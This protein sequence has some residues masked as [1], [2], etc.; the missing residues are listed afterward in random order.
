MSSLERIRPTYTT[1]PQENTVPPLSSLSPSPIPQ[2]VSPTPTRLL[3]LIIPLLLSLII[4]PEG[5]ACPVL[6]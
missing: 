5:A 3:S 4:P 6:L 2:S 1:I